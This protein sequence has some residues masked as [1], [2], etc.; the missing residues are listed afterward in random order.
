[1][2]IYFSEKHMLRFTSS[3]LSVYLKHIFDSNTSPDDN[4]LKISGYKLI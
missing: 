1:M 2:Q 4:N 3:I